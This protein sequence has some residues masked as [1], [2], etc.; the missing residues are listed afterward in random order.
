MTV[1]I[2]LFCSHCVETLTICSANKS[3][4]ILNFAL[5]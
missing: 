5:T 4:N 3:G 2:E 1:E